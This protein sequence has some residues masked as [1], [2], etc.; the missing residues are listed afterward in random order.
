[1][2]LLEIDS[3]PGEFVPNGIQD[4][5]VGGGETC[6]V[7]FFGAFGGLAAVMRTLPRRLKSRVLGLK[8]SAE[9]LLCPKASGA[10]MQR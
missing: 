9:V 4:E 3:D 10:E 7:L 8:C 2:L 6:R 5:N 1:M